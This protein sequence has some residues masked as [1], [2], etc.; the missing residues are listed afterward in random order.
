MN[1]NALIELEKV[2]KCFT[3]EKDAL[4]SIDLEIFPGDI[5]G[6]IGRSGAGKSTLLRCL[7]GLDAPTSGRVFFD[8]EDLSLQGSKELRKKKQSM[9][10]VFQHFN[11][12]SS[13]TAF[14]N[15]S[16]PLEIAK[17]PDEVRKKKV[18]HLLSLVGLSGKENFYPAT[19]SGGEKQ[20]VAIARAIAND[21]KV[22]FCD[23]ATSALDPA[24][25]K[26]LLDLLKELKGKLN[27]TIVII[28]HQMEVI[29]EIC[30][31]VAV[32]EEGKIVEEGRVSD[33]FAAPKHPTTRRFLHHLTHDLPD[34]IFGNPN[35]ELL[36]LS[37]RGEKAKKPLIS[38]LLRHANIEVNI[39]AGSIDALQNEVVGHL[40]VEF[41]GD[42]AEKAKAHDFLQKEKITYER[43][44]PRELKE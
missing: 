9:G 8:G 32:L 42:E 40:V 6:I 44:T 39:L 37:F 5:F 27:L 7:C 24:N 1:K 16:F 33:L 34:H 25:V 14:G 38:R 13:R 35:Q 19:L 23:E 17:V 10:M 31:K 11:L 2:S 21:P 15:V 26:S 20:R 4:Q 28:T 12:L 29:R 30:T 3:P 41:V 43:L 36:R 22:L 18:P